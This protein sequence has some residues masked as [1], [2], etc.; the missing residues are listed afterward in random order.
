[1]RGTSFLYFAESASIHY[2]AITGGM[3]MRFVLFLLIAAG[4][5]LVASSSGQAATVGPETQLGSLS[6]FPDPMVRATDSGAEVIWQRGDEDIASFVST[7]FGQTFVEQDVSGRIPPYDPDDS[8]FGYREFVAGDNVYQAWED[9][10]DTGLLQA[11]IFFRSSSDGG[12]TWGDPQLIVTGA[13]RNTWHF[14]LSGDHIYFAYF[15]DGEFGLHGRDSHDGGATFED[16][17]VLEEELDGVFIE[18]IAVLP[19]GRAVVLIVSEQRVRT[20]AFPASGFQ[21]TPDMNTLDTPNPDI[22]VF[23]TGGD[24]Y[25]APTGELVATWLWGD[26]QDEL[27]EQFSSASTDGED[28]STPRLLA[29]TTDSSSADVAL[30]ADTSYLVL[31]EHSN[32]GSDASILKSSNHGETWSKIGDEFEPEGYVQAVW[33]DGDDVISAWVLKDGDVATLQFVRVDPDGNRTVSN[34][35]PIPQPIS[36]PNNLRIVPAS[37]LAFTTGESI[38]APALGYVYW[39]SDELYIAPIVR[40]GNVDCDGVLGPGDVSGILRKVAGASE[41]GCVSA[42]D[43]NCDEEYTGMDALLMLYFLGSLA[44]P[45]EVEGCPAPGT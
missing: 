28:W 25:Q 18:E 44:P 40:T 5:C 33:L 42:G 19:N 6:I 36:V 3:G 4:V 22:N 26:P 27:W 45:A 15:L 9:D 43:L 10:I 23:R 16:A 17:E 14:K 34:S 39:L 38:P 35:D 32:S 29:E 37:Q 12:Q 41:P 8:G 21:G 31:I 2:G 20:Y 11:N 7:D 24:L 30:G 1:M 13:R